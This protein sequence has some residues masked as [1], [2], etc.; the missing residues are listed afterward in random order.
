MK[1][2]YIGI[3]VLLVLLG[4]GYLYSNKTETTFGGQAGEVRNVF[5][6]Q[7][8]TTTAP[9]ASG[10]FFAAYGSNASTSKT[11]LLYGTTDTVLFTVK[12]LTA[13]SSS[14]YEWD[15]LG[16]NDTG[17]NT[18]ATSSTDEAYTG[19][20]LSDINWYVAD[21]TNSRTSGRV[22]N[23]TA[24]A[25]GTIATLTNL[26]WSCLRFGANGSSTT[27]LMQIREKSL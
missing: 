5:G 10:S 3:I 7:V 13:S 19:Y 15:I 23:P 18:T 25:T 24:N 11:L 14:F 12:A 27:V 8:G 17:C 2:I 21:P 20:K 9:T 22:T 4:I 1:K 26:N 16:S 6:T